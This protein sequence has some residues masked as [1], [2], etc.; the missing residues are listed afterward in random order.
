MLN[1][2][3]DNDD[4]IHLILSRIIKTNNP[5]VN[6]NAKGDFINVVIAESF[7]LVLSKCRRISRHV[8][9]TGLFNRICV[10]LHSGLLDGHATLYRI[11]CNRDLDRSF[12][13]YPEP[14][15]KRTAG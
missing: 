10:G 2:Y 9:D 13:S 1:E 12:D 4:S 5:N 15:A 7:Y 11:Q 8:F 6:K 14:Y 3:V